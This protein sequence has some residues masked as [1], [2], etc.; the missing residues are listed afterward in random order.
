MNSHNKQ[1]KRDSARVAF[2]VCGGFWCLSAMRKLCYCVLHPLTGRYVLG[3]NCG[4][5]EG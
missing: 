3:G 2:L 5:S 4:L 1:F